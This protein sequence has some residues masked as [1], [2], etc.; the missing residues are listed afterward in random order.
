MLKCVELR[1]MKTKTYFI[2]VC[3]HIHIQN[4]YG[5]LRYR[6]ALLSGTTHFS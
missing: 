1:E 4:S 2:I 3:V 6:S 5:V